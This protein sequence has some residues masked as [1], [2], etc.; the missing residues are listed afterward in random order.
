MNMSTPYTCYTSPWL[1][2][3][4]YVVAYNYFCK[5][6]SSEFI[7]NIIA[8]VILVAGSGLAIKT[9][10]LY[11]YTSNSKMNVDTLRARLTPFNR[12]KISMF[13]KN[14]QDNLFHIASGPY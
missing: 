1:Y 4:V 9:T 5:L 10:Y 2:Q 3:A 7:R 6:R 13:R 12:R 14:L 11:K 8:E